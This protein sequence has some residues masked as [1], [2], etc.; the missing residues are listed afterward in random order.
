MDGLVRDCSISSVVAVEILQSCTEPSIYDASV[1]RNWLPNSK[2][3]IYHENTSTSD[4]LSK[5]H[6]FIW[7]WDHLALSVMEILY[8]AGGWIPPQVINTRDSVWLSTSAAAAT[9]DG[10]S[11]FLSVGLFICRVLLEKLRAV[12]KYSLDMKTV[13]NNNYVALGNIK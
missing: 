5:L 11:G 8:A 2:H 1:V 9:G 4:H 12:D 7:C 6:L 13:M 10:L 3:C